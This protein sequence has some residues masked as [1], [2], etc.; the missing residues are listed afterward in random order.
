MSA[1]P[2]SPVFIVVSESDVAGIAAADAAAAAARYRDEFGDEPCEVLASPL[3]TSSVVAARID[4]VLARR[5][6]ARL[7]CGLGEHRYYGAPEDMQYALDDV[8]AMLEEYVP[9]GLPPLDATVVSQS[10]ESIP[11]WA[12]VPRSTPEC[13]DE[14][15]ICGLCAKCVADG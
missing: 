9:S 11:Y 1:T 8:I 7:L 13:F 12:F 10:G 4:P 2:D 15:A 5:I 3:P 14:S 6:T